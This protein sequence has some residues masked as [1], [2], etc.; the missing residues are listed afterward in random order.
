MKIG[1]KPVP[2][3]SFGKITGKN[4]IVNKLLL[5]CFFIILC[6]ITIAYIISSVIFWSCNSRFLFISRYSTLINHRKMIEGEGFAPDQYRF[7]S[8]YLVD[9]I[10]KHIAIPWYDI[11]N[12]NLSEIL[13]NKKEWDEETKKGINEFFPIEEREKIIVQIDEFIDNALE[14]FIPD[15]LLLRKLVRSSLSNTEW[16]TYIS[17]PASMTTIIADITPEEMKSLTDPQSHENKIIYGYNTFN[18]FFLTLALILL[19]HFNKEFL[20]SFNA[21]VGMILFSSILPL[22]SQDSLQPETFF[23]LTVFLSILLAIKRKKSYTIITLFILLGCTVRTDLMFFASLLYFLNN[24]QK[25]RIKKVFLVKSA[26][27][28]FI[29][30]LFTLFVSR[31]IYSNAQYYMDLFQYSYNFKHIWSWIFPII[32]LSLPIFFSYKVKE[33]DFYRKTWLWIVPFI[34]TNF[35]VARTAE[36][37]LFIPVLAYSVPFIIRGIL[38]IFKTEKEYYSVDLSND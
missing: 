31:V 20:D 1:K 27:L 8:Y 30:V 22:M 3:E 32:F 10:F 2:G 12:D 15:N 24:F 38:E 21:F 17:N 23:A 34:L 16:K 7:G 19:Y 13:L 5:R 36:V 18:F 11:F 4:M 25:Y 26:F 9:N 14:E 33:I 35:L 37:R 29:P 6:A 28:M